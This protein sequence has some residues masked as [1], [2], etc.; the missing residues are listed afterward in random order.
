L[1]KKSGVLL[2]LLIACRSTPPPAYP[3]SLVEL[4]VRISPPGTPVGRVTASIDGSSATALRHAAS[5]G[6]WSGA[7]AVGPGTHSVRIEA[8][9]P[10]SAHLGETSLSVTTARGEAA[11]VDAT[12]AAPRTA[13]TVE[14]P[15]VSLLIAPRNSVVQGEAISLEGR[16]AGGAAGFNW[17]ME[18]AGCGSFA[19]PAAA[20][21]LWTAIAAGPC[22]VTL[23]TGGQTDRRSLRLVVRSRGDPGQ[24][25]LRAAPGGRYLIDA[26]GKPF[27]IK[28]ETAWLL[29]ANL[30]LAEQE[31]Y[32]ADRAA[33]G[34]NLVEIMLTNHDYTS[35]PNPP[36]PANRAGEQPFLRP[37]D[38]SKP[39]DAYF[40]R[41]VAFV[42]RAAAHGIAVLIAPNY[43]GFDG[44]REGW[45]KELSDPVNTR[46]VCAG[47]GRYVG[48][49]FK[50]RKNVLW[51]AGGDFAPPPG[52][53]GEARHW[54]I[55][56][57]IREAGAAQPWTGH[58]NLDHRGG[59]STDQP[60]F[61]DAMALNG[62]YQ[63]AQTYRFALRAY[64]VQPPRPVFLL[65]SNYE[66]E[67][68]RGDTQPFRKAWWWTMLSGGSGVLWSNAFLWLCESA[69]GTYAIDYGDVDHAVSSWAAE[70]ESPGTKEMIHLH[71]LFEGLPWHRLVP[72]GAASG[73]PELVL[74]G[75][76]GGLLH[77]AA[78]ATPEGDLLVLYVPPA[79]TGSRSFE[80]DLS[81]MGGAVRAR[82]YDP[83]TGGSIPVPGTVGS[84]GPYGFD[85]PGVNG[86]GANDWV[87][88]VEAAGR[89][90]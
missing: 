58:W 16:A 82:W 27:L 62:V 29:L 45:W 70:L 35:A 79:G 19:Q 3:G 83:S 63:Y 20:T 69:R 56:N 21:T 50:D 37:G 28:G 53:E 17:S 39:N 52:S 36:P 65:E 60:R 78:A 31:R 14:T 41:A 34:F 26:R 51:L 54:E 24:Y 77:I 32:L 71:A 12:V 55:L 84:A 7:L 61:R 86:S 88:I 5:A 47:F 6:E 15:A 74:R 67:H 90:K 13:G 9:N 4:T 22:T 43:L 40:D 89:R 80:V 2:A 68:P 64:D 38:F 76:G 18:P 49:R 25:P 44:G 30:T 11:L 75:R 87:L 46:A 81:R 59:I 85:T 33:K 66:H 57:G 42:D 73:S 8:L 1:R 23:S 48:A 72:A 10:H